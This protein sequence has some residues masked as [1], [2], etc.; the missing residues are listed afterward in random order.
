M[1]RGGRALN[2]PVVYAMHPAG[3]VTPVQV[4][5]DD[6]IAALS[7]ALDALDLYAEDLLDPDWFAGDEPVTVAAAA[8]LGAALERYGDHTSGDDV[9]GLLQKA[10]CPA[11]AADALAQ[12]FGFVAETAGH[13]L[14]IE[15]LR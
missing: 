6:T 12:F 7:D 1:P 2:D 8:R 13:D 5:P 11:G 4:N 14:V 3:E 9:A 15:H 10:Q